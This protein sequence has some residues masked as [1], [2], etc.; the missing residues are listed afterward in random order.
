MRTVVVLNVLVLFLT[1]GVGAQTNS[2]ASRP[3]AIAECMKLWDRGTHMT[4]QE[5]AATCR[6][7]QDRVDNASLAPVLTAAGTGSQGAA[8]P[9]STKLATAT[10]G[11]TNKVAIQVNQNDK[12]VRDLA[13]NNAKNVLD[14]YKDKGETVAIE[15]V[16]F[17]PGLHMLRADTSP[18]KDRIA[19]MS[20]E[21]PNLRFIACATHKPTRA[22][23]KASPSR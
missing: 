11:A 4:K 13:L 2:P 10:P 12:A 16:T 8:K 5:W 18:V 1:P 7:V 20:L 15:I 14:Y 22:R 17:G 6:R 19:P 21:H 23:R 9:T 3:D